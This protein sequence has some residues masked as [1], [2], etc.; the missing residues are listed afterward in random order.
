MYTKIQVPRSMFYHVSRS[1]VPTFPLL[2]IM[3]KLVDDFRLLNSNVVK[4]DLGTQILVHI[5]ILDQS[6]EWS[7]KIET[8]NILGSPIG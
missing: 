4:I 7:L 5:V 1:L 8:Q 2:A 6:Q 3:T